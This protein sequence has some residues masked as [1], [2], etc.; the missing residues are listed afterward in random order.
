MDEASQ[1]TK[2]TSTP[3]TL[4]LV[5]GSLQKIAGVFIIHYV[6]CCALMHVCGP[7]TN[8]RSEKL[9]A[10]DLPYF[11]LLFW[12]RKEGQEMLHIH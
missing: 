12:A 5:L 8:A 10:D 3:C 4:L 9:L 2:S 7:S 1:L 6:F 11:N